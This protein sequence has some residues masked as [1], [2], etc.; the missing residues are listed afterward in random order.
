MGFWGVFREGGEEDGKRF[1]TGCKKNLKQ[2]CKKIA[3]IFEAKKISTEI[4][5][6]QKKF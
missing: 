2:F 1:R 5:E 6:S 3:N 4:P